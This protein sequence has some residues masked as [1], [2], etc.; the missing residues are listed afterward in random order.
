MSKSSEQSTK[1]TSS[2]SAK[3]SVRKVDDVD[4][5][6]EYHTDLP[7]ASV[8]L[9]I[10]TC[11]KALKTEVSPIID[12]T[13]RSYAKKTPKGKQAKSKNTGKV[14]EYTLAI[15]CSDDK[16]YKLGGTGEDKDIG[17][18]GLQGGVKHPD[19]RPYGLSIMWKTKTNQAL[20]KCLDQLAKV[21]IMDTEAKI[22]NGTIKIKNKSITNPVKDEIDTLDV[23]AN[24]EYHNSNDYNVRM[25]IITRGPETTRLFEERIVDN[26]IDG[27][28]VDIGD[29]KFLHTTQIDM[30][31]SNAHTLFTRGMGM[32]YFEFGITRKQHGFGVSFNIFLSSVFPIP[33]AVTFN[34][35][36]P[37]TN[38]S[39]EKR[40]QFAQ[41]AAER[42]K[43]ASSNANAIQQRADQKGVDDDDDKKSKYS[44]KINTDKKTIMRNVAPEQSESEEGDG[45]D[46]SNSD[47][48]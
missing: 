21:L 37:K 38:R 13:S 44:K 9:L 33:R 34:K 45:D 6:E 39:L 17:P 36:K 41:K 11:E 20:G 43:V 10:D 32:E 4:I 2:S 22:K 40:L 15:L 24:Q 31:E 19:N 42:A 46:F 12:I 5:K 14:H 29:G 26:K 7:Y 1:S 47:A 18:H 30:D 25:S 3:L 16:L 28:D 8:G 23:S 48:E 35:A 27:E